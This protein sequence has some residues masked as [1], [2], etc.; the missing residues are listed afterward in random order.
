MDRIRPWLYLGRYRDTLDPDLLAANRI[1]AMLQLAEAVTQRGIAS[2]YLPVE[3]G[4]PLAEDL[5]RQGIGFILSEKRRGH[6][7]LIACGAG[8]SR[9]VAYA[10]AVLKEEEE[11]S[12]L[13]ALRAV[14]HLYP[15]SMLHPALWE[16]LCHYYG[17]EFSLDSL[18]DV[19]DSTVG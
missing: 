13:E 3:D 16:S 1:D 7:V 14:K 8:M 11:L 18:L 6:S 19:V 4:K 12:L 17:E 5:L 2:L 9:S 10:I 15:D